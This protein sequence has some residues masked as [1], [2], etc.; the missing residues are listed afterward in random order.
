LNPAGEEIEITVTVE[1]AEIRPATAV[2][3]VKTSTAATFNE[4]A[5]ALILIQVVWVEV[6]AGRKEINI[7][8]SI[9]V[10]RCET[11]GKFIDETPFPR[12]DL[13]ASA[14]SR[15]CGHIGE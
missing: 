11:T 13:P 9:V 10:G 1:V 8:V 6:T 14:Q 3:K 2:Y 4:S 12:H 15:I 5:I 7:A